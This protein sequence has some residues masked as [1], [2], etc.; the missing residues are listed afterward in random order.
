[1]EAARSLPPCPE[2]TEALNKAAF[3][4]TVDGMGLLFAKRG[5]P[6]GENLTLKRL[7]I[8]PSDLYPAARSFA[9]RE[10]QA[11]VPLITLFAVIRS[12]T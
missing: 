6:S 3:C 1:L 7:E 8:E 4:K 2:R 5:R 11:G 9:W 12:E 10:S